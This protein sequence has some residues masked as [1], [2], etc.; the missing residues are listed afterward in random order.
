[1]KDFYDSEDLDE[2]L[3]TLSEEE[4]GYTEDVPDDEVAASNRRFEEI[5]LKHRD[6][7]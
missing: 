2:L 1:M 5:I 7:N 4:E 6:P 3:K